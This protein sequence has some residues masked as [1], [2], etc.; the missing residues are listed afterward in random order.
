MRLDE[1]GL[2]DAALKR[3]LIDGLDAMKTLTATF[4]GK[5]TDRLEV[6][7][8]ATR[9]KFLDLALRV[10]GMYQPEK[11]QVD[12][13]GGLIVIG[14]GYPDADDALEAPGGPQSNEDG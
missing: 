9:A 14:T 8:W 13:S 6:I 1:L 10:K 12:Q 2:S 4:K 7:D 3:K 5:I 11:V